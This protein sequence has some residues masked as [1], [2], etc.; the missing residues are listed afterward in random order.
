MPCR[1]G[2]KRFW[3]QT[4]LSSFVFLYVWSKFVTGS[5]TVLTI[6]EFEFFDI[7]YSKFQIVSTFSI[8]S[9]FCVENWFLCCDLSCKWVTCRSGCKR[10]FGNQLFKYSDKPTHNLKTY[11]TVTWWHMSDFYGSSFFLNILTNRYITL[12]LNGS[13]LAK[14]KKSIPDMS[15]PWNL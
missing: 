4:R 1:S 6:A 9:K 11:L 15:L 14:M 2:Q 7:F 12:R 5:E 3:N 13:Q 8:C 10:G